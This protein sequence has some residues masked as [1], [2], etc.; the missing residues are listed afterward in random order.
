MKDQ[1]LDIKGLFPEDFGIVFLHHRNAEHYLI[2][3]RL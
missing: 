2:K 3:R 1:L